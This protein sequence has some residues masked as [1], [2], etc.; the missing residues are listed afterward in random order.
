MELL[1]SKLAQSTGVMDRARFEL[2]IST[3]LNSAAQRR[4]QVE[5]RPEDGVFISVAL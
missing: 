1:P 4:L 3:F 2:A 5:H